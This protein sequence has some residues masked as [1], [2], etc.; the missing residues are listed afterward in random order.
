MYHTVQK[1]GTLFIPVLSEELVGMHRLKKTLSL[2]L[3]LTDN[4]LR[5][6]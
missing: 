1:A 3:L 5:A 4:R 2:H 6:A